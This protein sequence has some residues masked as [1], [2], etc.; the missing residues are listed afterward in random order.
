VDVRG[1]HDRRCR[2]A[3]KLPQHNTVQ[4][5]TERKIRRGGKHVR[6]ASVEE[7]RASCADD[8][9]QKQADF[10]HILFSGDVRSQCWSG[11][12]LKIN[13]TRDHQS[14]YKRGLQCALPSGTVPRTGTIPRTGGSVVDPST[15]T[16]DSISVL[17]Y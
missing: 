5:V 15:A 13:T 16:L 4:A 12:T 2:Y 10:L 1:E 9:S 7:M 6:K 11:H 14:T 17:V 8:R 3:Y